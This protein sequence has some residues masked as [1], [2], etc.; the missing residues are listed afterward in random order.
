MGNKA[1]LVGV[2]TLGLQ[3]SEN[4]T[5][6]MSACLAKHDYEIIKPYKKEKR[7][8]LEQFEEMLNKC[9]K[10]DTVIFYFSGHGSLSKGK[11]RLVLNEQPSQVNNL[12][13]ISEITEAFNSEECRPINKLIILDCCKAGAATADLQLDLSDAYRILTASTRLEKSKEIDEFKAG[14][15]TYTINQALTHYLDEIC[16]DQ[17]ITINALYEWLVKAAKQHNVKHSVQVPVPNLL[18]NAKA[19]FEIAICDSTTANDESPRLLA[20]KRLK[21]LLSAQFDDVLL[22]YEVPNEY[23]S[24]AAQ[25]MTP[26]SEL[27]KYA[28]QQEGEQL[29]HLFEVINEVTQKPNL[30]KSATDIGVYLINRLDQKIKL[31]QAIRAHNKKYPFLCLIH[32]DEHQRDDRFFDSLVQDELP[33]LTL[34]PDN[35]IPCHFFSCRFYKGIDQ[36]HHDILYYF[37]KKYNCDLDSSKIITTIEKEKRS[38]LFYTSMSTEN[39]SKSG[40]MKLIHEFFKFWANWSFPS[41]HNHLLL[42]CL[43]F[44]YIE[45]PTNFLSRWRKKNKTSINDKIRQEFQ[46]LNLDKFGVNCIVLPELKNIIKEDVENWVKEHLRDCLDILMPEIDKLFKSETEEK[47]MEYLVKQLKPILEKHCKRSF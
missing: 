39:W 29:T 47:T 24:T 28:R 3:Y 15:L 32:G 43:Y 7:S 21:T 45:K 12:I 27:I 6:L 17:K 46:Q 41:E 37:N 42:I 14:F 40:G 10:T 30:P 13:R 22:L 8:I 20:R 1:F 16:V 5:E 26:I 18:G 2:N 9:D 31:R 33:K 35:E 23:L 19:N 44:N 25:Q 34:T 38:I 11:L 36:V 4:D